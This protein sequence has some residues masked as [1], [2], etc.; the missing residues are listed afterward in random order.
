VFACVCV[1]EYFELEGQSALC[2]HV[3]GGGCV[4]CLYACLCVCVCECLCVCV[5][6]CNWSS[7]GKVCRMCVRACVCV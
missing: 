5:C 6:V 3:C 7:R 4:V 2:E 1:L